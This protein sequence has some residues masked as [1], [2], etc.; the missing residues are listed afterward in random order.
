MKQGFDRLNAGRGF[1]MFNRKFIDFGARSLDDAEF[2]LWVTL[3]GSANDFNDVSKGQI[4][5]TIY[6]IQKYLNWSIG[7]SSGILNRL[8]RKGFVMRNKNGHYYI[9]QS[10]EEVQTIAETFVQPSEVPVQDSEQIVQHSEQVSHDFT[11]YK[12]KRSL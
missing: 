12:D 4:K 2:M 11:S 3:S 6:D 9:A 5:V 1:L 10:P 7:K 8:I